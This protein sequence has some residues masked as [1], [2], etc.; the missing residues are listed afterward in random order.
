MISLSPL[1]TAYK[2]SSKTTATLIASS[3]YSEGKLPISILRIADRFEGTC[4]SS[5]SFAS[6]IGA[7][8]AETSFYK[9]RM[10]YGF[11]PNLFKAKYGSIC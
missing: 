3:R 5:S 1:V 10:C 9:G 4:S 8:V 7:I 11:G 6:L 2:I